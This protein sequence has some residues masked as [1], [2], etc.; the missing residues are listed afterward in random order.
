MMAADIGGGCNLIDK[1]S[2]KPY[3]SLTLGYLMNELLKVCGNR[4]RA[5][6]KPKALC[7]AIQLVS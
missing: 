6:E 5:N 2:G 1:M 3:I 7:F 4:G